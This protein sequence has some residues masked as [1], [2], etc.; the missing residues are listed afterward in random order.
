M[1][2]KQKLPKSKLRTIYNK[3]DISITCDEICLVCLFIFPF[4]GKHF[5][6]FPSHF[7]LS[8]LGSARL[9]GIILGA[10]VVCS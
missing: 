10:N 3:V 7:P 5:N 8:L 6:L 2:D 9:M 4:R 1:S